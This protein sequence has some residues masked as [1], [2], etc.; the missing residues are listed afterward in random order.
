MDFVGPF[1]PASMRTRS[2]Y[3]VVGME[4][5]TNFKWVEAKALQ[6]NITASITKFLYEDIWCRYACLIELISDQGGHF[7]GHVVENLKTFYAVFQKRNTPYYPQ[8]NRLAES[9]NKALQ[10]ILWKIVNENRMDW[11]TKLHSAMWAYR[12][13]YK[14]SIWMTPF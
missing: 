12:T 6:D 8:A 13:T 14:M 4:Y 2:K 1:K 9:T 11:D 3:I 5:C 7:I 10:N